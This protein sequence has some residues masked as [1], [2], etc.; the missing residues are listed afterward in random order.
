M[1]KNKKL[2]ASTICCK[3]V[4]SCSL[5]P[6]GWV[7][8]K[9]TRGDWA[10]DVIYI[11]VIFPPFF[12]NSNL[13]PWDDRWWGNSWWK[14]ERFD[15]NCQLI[16][17]LHREHLKRLEKQLLREVAESK[18]RRNQKSS[19]AGNFSEISFNFR[20]FMCRFLSEI[21]QKPWNVYLLNRTW[22]NRCNNAKIGRKFKLRTW[23]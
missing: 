15:V 9:C 3:V 1:Q 6:L 17:V 11:T 20:W 13:S 16:L 14:S 8:L 4:S 7:N 19:D 12:Q 10:E 18:S 21:C 2:T 22:E 23:K 5:S